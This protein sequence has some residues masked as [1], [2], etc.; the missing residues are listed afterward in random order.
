MKIELNQNQHFFGAKN[1]IVLIQADREKQERKE[2]EEAERLAKEEAE[3]LQKEKA[4]K[5]RE[6]RVRKLSARLP[7]E[8]KDEKA[9]G[10]PVSQLRFRIPA[11][12]TREDGETE[13]NGETKTGN[14][15]L[16]TFPFSC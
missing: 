14:F 13:V 4:D 10:Q 6:A 12:L 15:N 16:K 7:P 1:S 3:R 9:E 11:T 2:K 5:I 8:P